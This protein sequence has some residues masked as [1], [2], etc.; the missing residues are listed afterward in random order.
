VNCVSLVATDV[1]V[2][3][4]LCEAD[5]N[6]VLPSMFCQQ[7][8]SHRCDSVVADDDLVALYAACLLVTCAWAST[9]RKHPQNCK[10]QRP[11]PDLRP[12]EPPN[13]MPKAE[14]GVGF[15]GQ[16]QQAPSPDSTS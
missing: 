11:Q 8:V 9:S 7:T 15:F 13:E 12:K 2:S 3:E 6:V 4:S 1:A 5:V 14:S 10:A 16:W